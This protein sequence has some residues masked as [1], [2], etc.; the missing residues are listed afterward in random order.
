LVLEVLALKAQQHQAQEDLTVEI[1]HFPLFL[2]LAVVVAA[3]TLQ[4]ILDRLD[5]PVGLA[6]VLDQIA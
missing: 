3:L 5:F 2:L 6:V 1:L 4:I